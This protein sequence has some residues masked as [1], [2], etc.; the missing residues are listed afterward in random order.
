MLTWLRNGLL[1][2]TCAAALAGCTSSSGTSNAAGP[3]GSRQALAVGS[4]GLDPQPLESPATVNVV[5]STKIEPF[6]PVLL[7]ESLGEFKKENLTLKFQFLPGPDGLA[8]LT[9]RRADVQVTGVNGGF[10]NAVS[11]GQHV[12]WAANV[13]SKETSKQGFWARTSMLTASGQLDPAKLRGARVAVIGG[14]G[15]PSILPLYQELQRNGLGLNDVQLVN[16]TSAGDILAA[17]KQGSVD[18]GYLLSPFWTAAD[19][20][21]FA[22]LVLGQG[23]Q[24]SVYAVNQD[25]VATSPKVAQAFFRAVGRTVRDHLTGD[26]KATEQQRAAIAKA[27]EVQPGSLDATPLVFDSRLPL[28]TSTITQ[29]QD[30]WFKIGRIFNYQEPLAPEKLID[31]SVVEAVVGRD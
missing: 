9:T 11:A 15:N 23:F 12:R 18:V 16:M 28:D 31:R 24:A 3:G 26:Y 14:V 10:F 19:R 22:K 6:L 20:E 21:D 5:M 4:P 27:L 30:M 1:V 29:L 25:W 8:L 7:G 2:V 13:Y 17:L